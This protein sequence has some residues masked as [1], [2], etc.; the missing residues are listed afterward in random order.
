MVDGSWDVRSRAGTGMGI[1]NRR[2]D[3]VYVRFDKVLAIDPFQAEARAMVYALRYVTEGGNEGLFICCS[4]SKNLVQAIQNE[5]V[6]GL[7]SWQAAEEVKE[8]I[9]LNQM[10]PGKI[11]VQFITREAAMS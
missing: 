5:S 6:E 3:L 10:H 8:C 1:Y 7:P 11:Q 9:N 4:D 2:G